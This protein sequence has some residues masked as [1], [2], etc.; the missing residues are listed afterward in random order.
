MKEWVRQPGELPIEQ[1]APKD[2]TPEKATVLIPYGSLFYAASQAFEEELPSVTEE[3]KHAVVI[4]SLRQRDDL[5][6]T[7]FVVL[8]ALR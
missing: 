1:D 3:T 4:L 6:S 2:V 7:I 8:A 5:G